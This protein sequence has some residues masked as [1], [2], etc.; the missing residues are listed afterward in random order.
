MQLLTTKYDYMC[1]Y[2]FT[3]LP[4][5]CSF[6]VAARGT[7]RTAPWAPLRSS[8][9]GSKCL[10]T[11]FSRAPLPCPGPRP[12]CQLPGAVSPCPATWQQG[13]SPAPHRPAAQPGLSLSPREMPGAQGSP[14]APGCPAPWQGPWL[15][16]PAQ[17]P[18]GRPWALRP[19]P[20]GRE[21]TPSWLAD[22]TPPCCWH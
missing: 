7:P 14:S 8:G 10:G 6:P 18:P 19:P 22:H 12:L 21:W 9:V 11:A 13:R 2:F 5:S 4:L 15:T 1:K 16:R 20:Q 3:L 17:P